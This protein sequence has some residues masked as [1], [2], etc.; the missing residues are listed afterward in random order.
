MGIGNCRYYVNLL[1]RLPYGALSRITRKKCHGYSTM[2]PYLAGKYGLEIGGPSPIFCG[3]HLVPVYDTCGRID[4]CAF[5]AQTIWSDAADSQ[6]FGSH[7][8]KQFVAEACDLSA[9]PEETYEFVIASH[10]LE[11]TANPLLALQEWSRVL[12]PGGVIL[13]IVPDKRTTFD[14]KRPYTSFDHIE[15]DFQ[16][17]VSEDDL[18]H[19]GEILK[20]HD[21]GLDPGAGS[22]EQFSE[23]CLRN[24]SARAMH[25][26][27]FSP[28]V[29]AMMFTRL[30]MRVLSLAIE[31]PFHIIG[32][33]LKTLPDEHEK[34]QANNLCLLEENADWRRRDPF[35]RLRKECVG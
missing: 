33:A 29:L 6:K 20:L 21:L 2:E 22:P 17:N 19:L 27:V 23:R 12:I 4:N 13:L 10:V 1:R 34:I 16:A 14:H 28:E 8:G 9:V 3:K 31:R 15:A 32:V 26:H 18:T 35:R 30:Q 11:H 5:A 7:L 25:H 24:P